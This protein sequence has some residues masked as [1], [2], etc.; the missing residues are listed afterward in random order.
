MYVLLKFSCTAS[1]KE[2]V[3]VPLC[4][5][6]HN[7]FASGSTISRLLFTSRSCRSTISCLLNASRSCRTT[8]PHHTSSS[9]PASQ[10][11]L[12]SS[13]SVRGR[14]RQLY[15]WTAVTARR[16]DGGSSAANGRPRLSMNGRS[17]SSLARHPIG[18]GGVTASSRSVTLPYLGVHSSF[19]PL[20]CSR[21]SPTVS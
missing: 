8:V 18:G 20:Y 17:D 14:R 19:I 7:L 16:V 11:I 6:L 21:H 10:C 4:L 13:H 1:N 15:V 3:A 5:L 9:P 2:N 12:F